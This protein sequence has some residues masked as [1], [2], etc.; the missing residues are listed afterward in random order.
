[1]CSI[2]FFEKKTDF[3]D[4][5]CPQSLLKHS[6]GHFQGIAMKIC[7]FFQNIFW[8]EIKLFKI[9]KYD[10]FSAARRENWFGR[11]SPTWNFQ[12]EHLKDHLDSRLTC[13]SPFKFADR[14]V[15]TCSTSRLAVS[16]CSLPS[17]WACIGF[18]VSFWV[19]LSK[20]I[21]AWFPGEQNPLET[22][23]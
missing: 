9:S 12:G 5:F 2:F 23:P 19:N 15:T 22:V 3:I 8:I 6:V 11:R 4:K 16:G 20:K 13:K 14:F 17:V 18:H 21:V 7:F 1:M 10:S